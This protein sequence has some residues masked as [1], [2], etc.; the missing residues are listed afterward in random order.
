M[1][2]GSRTPAEPAP[3]SECVIFGITGVSS[4]QVGAAGTLTGY[5]ES[6][7]PMF[8]PIAPDLI[9]WASL[10]PSIAS[11]N[12][13][14]VRGIAPGFAV[15]QGTYAGM[16][17]QAALV[18]GDTPAVGSS[19]TTRLRIAGC[20]TM[21]VLQRGAFR[22]FA[23]FENGAVTPVDAVWTSSRPGVAGFVTPGAGADGRAL[24]AFTAGT[25]QVLA[26]YQGLIAPM[27]VAVAPR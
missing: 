25:T 27:A 24:D 12:A 6:C 1:N 4:L 22:A 10:D 21:T 20:P 9:T 7:R 18:V 14:V 8:L 19:P 23:V 13:G 17:Q 16:T 3:L 2:C 11:V 26:Q 5:Q 15:I